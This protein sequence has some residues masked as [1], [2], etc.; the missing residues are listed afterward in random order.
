MADIPD[1][2]LSVRQPWA[3]AIVAGHKVIENR[4]AGSIHA[5]RMTCRRIAVHAASA[6]KRDEY[7]WAVW[8]LEKHGVRC[9]AAAELVR[10]AIIGAVDVVDIVSE[11]DSAWFGGQMGLVLENAVACEPIPAK[12]ELGYFRWEQTDA[13]APPS[14]WMR[15]DGTAPLFDDLPPSFAAPP[16]KPFGSS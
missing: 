3:W 8:R 10:G 14:A 13:L 1:I 6:M 5:G 15:G 4:S 9:P 16:R 2:A 12:G 11:S 7:V